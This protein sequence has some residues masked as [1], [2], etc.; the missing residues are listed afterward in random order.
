V[1]REPQVVL[2][3]YERFELWLSC[4]WLALFNAFV[5]VVVLLPYLA[6]VLMR[7]GLTGLADRIYFL[8]V[9]L[10]HQLPQRSIFLFGPKLM[11]SLPEITTFTQT[12]DPLVLKQ[13]I[14]NA[15]LGWKV[16]YSDRLMAWYGSFWIASLVYAVIRRRVRP[17]PFWGLILFSLPMFIDGATHTISDIQIANQFGTGFRDTNLW[18]A[19]LTGNALPLWFVAGDAVGSF[20]SIMRWISGALFGIGLAWF[21]L[22]YAEGAFG[23]RR[24]ELEAKQAKRET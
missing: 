4:H 1:A 6:P 7:L 17:L 13:F 18:L 12:I 16:A 22:P 14:G 2:K 10:G 24:I 9:I 15:E 23:Y 8:Y 5:G 20:N 19:Q 21:L 3:W 11:Y